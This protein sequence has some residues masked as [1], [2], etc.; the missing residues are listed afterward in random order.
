[1]QI[2]GTDSPVNEVP[3]TPS[4]EVKTWDDPSAWTPESE[5]PPAPPRIADGVPEADALEQTLP[6]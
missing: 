3:G 6:A 2:F 1:M 4:D 5:E